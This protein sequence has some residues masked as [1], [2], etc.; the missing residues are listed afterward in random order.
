M[1]GRSGIDVDPVM[2]AGVGCVFEVA[3]LVD[4]VGQVVKPAVGAGEKGDVVGGCG[5]VRGNVTS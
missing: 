5:F 1:T 4:P 2:G 3:P